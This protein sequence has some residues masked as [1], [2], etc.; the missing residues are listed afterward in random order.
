MSEITH[1]SATVLTTQGARSAVQSNGHG[2]ARR[3]AGRKRKAGFTPVRE[4]EQVQR[5]RSREQSVTLSMR[6]SDQLTLFAGHPIVRELLVR[7]K[8]LT[9]KSTRVAKRDSV[10]L[11]L[12]PAFRPFLCQALVS[13][14]SRYL[15]L[16][17]LCCCQHLTLFNAENS[18][19]V[20]TQ[21]C[22]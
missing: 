4:R 14:H 7:E 3:C 13:M 20:S 11:L 2:G 19:P 1:V 18:L 10:G 9:E 5:H 12:S 15:L 21:A 17:Q 6:E 8:I 22:C 16:L